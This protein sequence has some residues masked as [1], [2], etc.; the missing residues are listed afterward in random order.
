MIKIALPLSLKSPLATLGLGALL[1]T[2]AP[3][4]A[5]PSPSFAAAEATPVRFAAWTIPVAAGDDEDGLSETTIAAVEDD[6][7]LEPA[8]LAEEQA[9]A[10][11]MRAWMQSLA[12][13]LIALLTVAL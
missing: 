13:G 6:S 8:Y 3:A 12:S 1:L 5:C 4:L 7:A 11:A 10:Q 2:A 9:T